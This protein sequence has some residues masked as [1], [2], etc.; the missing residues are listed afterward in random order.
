MST[1]TTE[2]WCVWHS[3]LNSDWKHSFQV[4]KLTSLQDLLGDPWCFLVVWAYP[5]KEDGIYS[6]YCIGRKAAFSGSHCRLIEVGWI[7]FFPSFPPDYTNMDDFNHVIMG[8]FLIAVVSIEL[9]CCSDFIVILNCFMLP[10]TLRAMPE[11]VV[12][13]KILVLAVIN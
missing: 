11:S 7:S 6:H 4:F 10:Q 12:L 1:E 2:L 9:P 5:Q 3:I 8:M 13:K